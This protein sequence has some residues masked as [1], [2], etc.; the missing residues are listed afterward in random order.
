VVTV[1]GKY[2][3]RSYRKPI[4]LHNL[5]SGTGCIDGEAKIK[6]S[7]GLKKKAKDIQVGDTVLTGDT[8]SKVMTVFMH[9]GVM[10]NMVWMDS[11]WITRGHPI[12]IEGDWKRPDEIYPKFEERYSQVV[13]FMLD[14]GHTVVVG[15][16]VEYV[17]CT[18]GKYTGDRLARLYP[19][20]HQKY[21]LDIINNGL[22]RTIQ[23]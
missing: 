15:D 16:E 5:T 20:N 1:A 14:E 7:N 6:L 4:L 19:E 9:P 11:F 3:T 12:L 17:C 13:N 21:Y 8:S 22:V 2:R 18:L 23:S 10:R